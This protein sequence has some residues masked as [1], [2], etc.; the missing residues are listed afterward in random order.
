MNHPRISR[1]QFIGG[2]SASVA[3]VMVVP[4][5]ILGKGV[6]APSDTLNIAGVGVGGRGRADLEGCRS[7]NIVALC[8]VDSGHAASTFRQYPNAAVYS[9]YRRMFDQESDLDAVIIATPD[10]T[11]AVIAIEA[12]KRGKHVYCEKPLTRTVAEA[13]ALATMAREAGVVTQM[14]NQGHA[15]EGTRQIREWIDA[16]VIGTVREVHYWTNRPI[17][18]QAIDRPTDAH[19]PPPGLDWDLFLGPAPYRPYHPAYH[20]FRWRGWW[21]YGTGALGDIAC[22]SMD[23]AFW[24]L[25]LGQPNRIEAETTRLFSETAPAVSRIIY[26]FPARDT[27]PPVRFVWRDGS[28]AMPRP[29]ELADGERLPGG[30]S[31]QLFVGDDG[32]IGADMYARGP[33]VFPTSLHQDV[34][35][36]PP[37]QTYPRSPGVYQEWIDACKGSG[38]TGAGFPD[39]AGPLTEVVLLGNL[40]V[41]TG[42]AIE[43]DASR[44]RAVNVP[45]ANR[46]LD[47]EYRE[48]WS[49]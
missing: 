10:H 18:P 43:W 36:S 23:A 6:Q 29:P 38:K 42:H 40:A 24:A 46:F 47:E 33:R 11:H 39:H 26:D 17:W 27:R 49:L 41:R 13:R 35:A 4:R 44:M 37:D 2:A 16:G 22:H 14:G 8:D 12:M 45:E 21:D 31:G 15:G 32:V 48:G 34:I 20:P 19:H 25:Q 28:L 9:D 3:S 5:H 1:R 30:S 7:Q